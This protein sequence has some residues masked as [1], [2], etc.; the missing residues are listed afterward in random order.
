MSQTLF[1]TKLLCHKNDPETSHEAAK[2]MVESGKLNKQQKVES[3]KLNKQQKVESG[4]LNKQQKEVS[5]MIIHY[6]NRFMGRIKDFTA[7]ELAEWTG[8]SPI[9]PLL[10]YYVIQRRLHE[11]T[12][13]E[14]TGE[15]RN[16][17]A[18]WRL[19]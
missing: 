4:K 18:V 13:I 19:K 5:D 15:K 10:T 6:H 7:K 8:Q 11:L 9:Y 3:G 14:R 12:G 16:G 1:E 17:C 2:K